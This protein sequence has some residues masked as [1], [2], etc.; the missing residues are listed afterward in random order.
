MRLK[1][2][3]IMLKTGLS[4]IFFVVCYIIYTTR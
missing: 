2:V 4:I 1:E 3:T